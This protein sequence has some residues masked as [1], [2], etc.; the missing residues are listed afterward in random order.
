MGRCCSFPN[1][2]NKQK[3]WSAISFHKLPL[4]DS[5]RYKLWLR[6]LQI[7]PNISKKTLRRR[8]LM[9]CSEHFAPEDLIH[10]EERTCPTSTAVPHS[11]QTANETALPVRLPYIYSQL[12]Q[13]SGINNPLLLF[14]PVFDAR[15]CQ[16]KEN[17]MLFCLFSTWLI[18]T[19]GSSVLSFISCVVLS[20]IMMLFNGF[21][22]FEMSM[23]KLK[24]QLNP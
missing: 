24:G 15:E 18:K 21:Y 13:C 20:Y 3:T 2:N 8:C 11:A 19:Q 7:D 12:T 17:I 6:A 9:V 22:T 10:H 16:T 23:C 1:C 5:K 4:N 14:I